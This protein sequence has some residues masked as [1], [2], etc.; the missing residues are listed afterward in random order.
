MRRILLSDLPTI[1][2]GLKALL[3]GSDLEL[4]DSQPDLE[5]L[6]EA[7]SEDQP[8]LVLLEAY[9]PTDP[10][11]PFLI[12]RHLRHTFPSVPVVVFTTMFDE[13]MVTRAKES[14][15]TAV[16]NKAAERNVI[17]DHFLLLTRGSGPG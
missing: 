10:D 9:L 12:V 6:A 5:S 13:E 1:H 2:S 17:I 15:A 8:D 3:S 4:I 14:G 7:V 16:V 11:L